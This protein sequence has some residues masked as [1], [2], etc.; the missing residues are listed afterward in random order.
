MAEREGRAIRTAYF[1]A[2]PAAT[3]ADFAAARPWLL[4]DHRARQTERALDA[5]PVRSAADGF[6][7][8]NRAA[9]GPFVNPRRL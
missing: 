2:N 8:T 9:G 1:A 4:A 7:A 6:F 3:E 5:A